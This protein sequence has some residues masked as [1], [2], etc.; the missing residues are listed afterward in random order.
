MRRQ[1]LYLLAALL[2]GGAV[3][4]CCPEVPVDFVD[5]LI[6]SGGHGHV[7]VGANVPFG[8]VQLGPTSIPVDWDWCSGYH[9]SDSTVIGFSHTHLS[10]TGIGDLFDVTVMPVVG[11]VTYARGT[12]DDP[13]SGLWSYAD[14]TREIARPGY[15]SVPL[16][17]YGILAE[18][19][20]TTRA[21]F[22]RYTFPEASDAAIVIDLENGG[23][24]DKTTESGFRLEEGGAVSGWRFSRGWAYD[25]KL[26]F[27][28]EVSKPAESV[29]VIG[30]R[31]AR[32]NLRTRK[33]EKVLLKV[34]I[35]AVSEEA[36]KAALRSEIPGWNFDKVVSSSSSAWNAELSKIRVKGLSP[37]EKRIFYTALYH[38]MT[39]PS[40][41]GEAD[42]EYR[43]ADRMLHKGD[44]TNYTTFSLWDTYRTAMPLMTIVHPEKMN[45]IV[46][47]MFEIFRQQGDLP[48]WHLMGNET[49][50]MVGDPGIIAFA[51]AVVKGFRAGL[52]D[53][54]IVEALVTTAVNPERGKGPRREMGYVPADRQIYSVSYDMEYAIADAA[55]ASVA[56]AM[57]RK[58]LADSYRE[59]S[60]SWRN[61]WDPETGFLRGKDSDGAF[62]EPFNPYEADTRAYVE[63]NAW[64]YK[65]L[66]PHDLPSLVE[67]IGSREKALED[68]DALFAASEELG[69]E[70]PPDMSG[71]I[72]QYVHG[73]EPSHHIIYFYTM[74]GEPRR[75]AERL[76]EVYARFYDD[77]PEGL[78]GNEDVGQMS[79]WYVMSV[80]GFYQ[81]EPASTRF[82]FGAP[83]IPEAVLKVAGGEFTIKA[84][85]LSDEN[86]YISEVRLNGE[87]YDLPYIEYNDIVRGGCLE[88]IMGK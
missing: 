21:G 45:D 17:R 33:G 83:A 65:W 7:F 5:P 46:R 62:L 59:R 76:R 73:N 64:Q 44:F 24:W 29:E 12:E 68:L 82:F 38:T 39:A 56:S 37:R 87:P 35:S 85:G 51:D 30:D 88:F 81:V 16:E 80:L 6:G 32:I 27:F 86:A 77:T 40:V 8:S 61:Y 57:G 23:C 72:G 54:E 4:G 63:G 2:A 34:G 18:M 74:L 79:A 42:G 26:F 70:A 25:Q 36:A 49:N 19:T 14:R 84:T 1:P 9:R 47:T 58:A 3:I 10:G 53:D 78:S 13:R 31:Y 43:G 41:F 60:H 75:A 66:V 71:L 55:V 11:D 67:L 20:A 28:A 22:H 50:C 48:V 69:S 15:Y 52:T